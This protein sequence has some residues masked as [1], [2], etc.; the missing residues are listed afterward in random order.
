M[1]SS[2][3]ALP[4][5]LIPSAQLKAA[6]YWGQVFMEVAWLLAFRVGIGSGEG[7]TSAALRARGARRGSGSRRLLRLSSGHA[8]KVDKS[9]RLWGGAF[10]ECLLVRLPAAGSVDFRAPRDSRTHPEIARPGTTSS[11]S[12]V[13]H[14][15]GGGSRARAERTNLALGDCGRLALDYPPPV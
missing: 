7:H 5:Q 13:S 2:P 3:A 1:R 12:P 9:V 10:D 14:L 15:A 8:G 11:A 4:P 6:K